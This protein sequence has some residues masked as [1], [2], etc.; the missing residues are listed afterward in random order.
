M[1]ELTYDSR[2][3]ILINVDGNGEVVGFRIFSLSALKFQI[4]TVCDDVM[5]L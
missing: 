1:K 3:F 4:D 5:S 2:F